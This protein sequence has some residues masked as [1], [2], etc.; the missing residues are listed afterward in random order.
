MSLANAGMV[1]ALSAVLALGLCE[2]AMAGCRG[3]GPY[4]ATGPEVSVDDLLAFIR[5]PGGL[6]DNRALTSK[7]MYH[8]TDQV[9]RYIAADNTRI[10][11]VAGAL[12]SIIVR[13]TPQQKVAIG[14]GLFRAYAMCRKTS[15][16][17]SAGAM[18]ALTAIGN[19]D[20]STAFAIA[21]V[22]LEG[23]PPS[24]VLGVSSGVA[25][26][27]SGGSLGGDAPDPFLAPAIQDPFSAVD[28]PKATS[29]Q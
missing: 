5:K 3:E 22:S 11:A 24:P 20:V 16:V 9:S 8:F 15:P 19:K 12:K 4:K 13:A 1:V 2:S 21:Q 23:A 14:R 26:D 17:V 25:P 28:I 27:L 10:A 18:A 29:D 7:D 6:L